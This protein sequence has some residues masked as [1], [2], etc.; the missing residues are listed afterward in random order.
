MYIFP[1]G[2]HGWGMKEDFK[3]HTQMLDLL[4]MWLKDMQNKL[5]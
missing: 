1:E 3:Y 5:K 4:G 2:G